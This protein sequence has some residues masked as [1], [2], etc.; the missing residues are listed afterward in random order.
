MNTPGPTIDFAVSL[1]GNSEDAGPG[2]QA[3]WRHFATR[4]SGNARS[5][6]VELSQKWTSNGLKIPLDQYQPMETDKQSYTWFDDGVEREYRTPAYGISNLAVAR[7]AIERFVTENFDGYIE[8]HMRKATAITQK[9]FRAA[10]GHKVCF[11]LD[12]SIRR[13]C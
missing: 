1:R 10:Q 6:M 7:F 11:L 2:K 8:V 4:R 5:R 3:I 13:G 9:T 12:C